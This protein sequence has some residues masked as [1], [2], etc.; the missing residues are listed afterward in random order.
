VTPEAWTAVGVIATAVSAVLV[1]LIRQARST[2]ELRAENTSQHAASYG[3][4]QSIDART[5]AID[6]KLDQH[7]ERL[8]ALE[9]DVKQLKEKN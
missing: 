7:G 1:A 2:R 9:H 6:E 5:M 8:V 4:L 3:L